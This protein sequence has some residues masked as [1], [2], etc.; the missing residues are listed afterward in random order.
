MNITPHVPTLPIATVV[1]PH[2]DNLRRENNNREIITKPE[3]AAQSAAEKGL[4]SEKDKAKTPAQQND[5]YNFEALRKKAELED[6]T[7]NSDAQDNEHNHPEKD[8]HE[9]HKDYEEFIE[10]KEIQQLKQRDAEVRTHE[11]AHAAVGGPFTGA[12]SYTFDVGPDGKKYAVSGEVSVDLSP[13]D[14]DPQATIAKMQ[15]VHAAALAPANPSVQDT[16]VAAKAAQLIIEAQSELLAQKSA[17][18]SED[19]ESNNNVNR[20]NGSFEPQQSL[21]EEDE[22][23][24]VRLSKEFDQ[25]MNDNLKAQEQY[26]SARENDVNE[27]ASRI[28]SFYSNINQ[29][30]EKPPRYQFE[31]T[32]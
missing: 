9:Q 19:D 3:A 16:K 1:N 28:E 30:Y 21:A 5:S 24:S 32:A 22:N 15:K 13:I 4:G 10:Q 14:G 8:S 29:A 12:P 31:L 17:D 11:Q 23:S 18:E 25:A 20:R 2:T 27:R 7:I 26:P 6:T